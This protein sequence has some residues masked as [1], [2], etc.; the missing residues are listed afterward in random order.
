MH[1]PFERRMRFLRGSFFADA[2]N[3]EREGMTIQR[4]ERAGG[5]CVSEVMTFV[6]NTFKWR[7]YE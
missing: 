5:D 3:D 4:G 1:Y 6:M 2:L 7:T